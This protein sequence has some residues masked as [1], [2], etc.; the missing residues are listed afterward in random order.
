[1][2]EEKDSNIKIVKLYIPLLNEG[3]PVLRPTTGMWLRG[4]IYKVLA[5][6]NYDPEDEEW[7][8]PP[9]SIVECRHE[10]Q[11]GEAVLVARKKVDLKPRG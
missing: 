1:M 5:V 3:T 6:E 4:N 8:F 10:L 9:E 11:N 7:R 2:L